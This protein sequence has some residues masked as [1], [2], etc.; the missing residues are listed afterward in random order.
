MIYSIKSCS[1]WKDL[2]C[3]NWQMIF[4]SNKH[5]LHP[6]V[7]CGR[8]FA[9]VVFNPAT[10][11]SGKNQRETWSCWCSTHQWATLFSTASNSSGSSFNPESRRTRRWPHDLRAAWLREPPRGTARQRRDNQALPGR[12]RIKKAFGR[13]VKQLHKV[14]VEQQQSEQLKRRKQPL[15]QWD[16]EICWLGNNVLLFLFK[17]MTWP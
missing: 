5:G 3:Y 12:A 14:S 4:F 1:T 16:R 10:R 6:A 15:G 9:T 8:Q 7:S 17:S 13:R 2:V 11:Q